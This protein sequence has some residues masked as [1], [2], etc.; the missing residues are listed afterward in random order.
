MCH[1]ATSD[2]P[3][4]RIYLMKQMFEERHDGVDDYRHRPL[5]S[6]FPA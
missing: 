3:R 1:G 5:P 4:G 6:C 2:S